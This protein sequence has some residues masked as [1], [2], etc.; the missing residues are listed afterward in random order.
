MLKLDTRPPWPSSPPVFY[1]KAAAPEFSLPTLQSTSS[2][3]SVFSRFSSKSTVMGGVICM[4]ENSISHHC[5]PASSRSRGVARSAS[6]SGDTGREDP[7]WCLLVRHETAAHSE[8]QPGDS[9]RGANGRRPAGPAD[10]AAALGGQQEQLN[11]SR[12][13]AGPDG[14]GSGTLL[15]AKPTAVGDRPAL[16]LPQPFPLGEVSAVGTAGGSTRPLK[17]TGLSLPLIQPASSDVVAVGADGQIDSSRRASSSSCLP[18]SLLP[19]ISEPHPPSFRGRAS[20]PS[21]PSVPTDNT[22]ANGPK[23]AAAARGQ[24]PSPSP[25][26]LCPPPPAALQSPPL[27]QLA[28]AAASATATATATAAATASAPIHAHKV[29]SVL[30]SDLIGAAV[31]GDSGRGAVVAGISRCLPP[32]SP[33][34]PP[35]ALIDSW[36]SKKRTFNEYQSDVGTKLTGIA[37]SRRR[38]PPPGALGGITNPS[39]SPTSKDLPAVVS[40]GSTLGPTHVLPGPPSDIKGTVPFSSL[41]DLIWDL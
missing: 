4:S 22:P 20:S 9:P 34:S 19:S 32:S 2:T 7:S 28:Q 24:S 33:S 13:K 14:S 31:D 21:S 29:A 23:P 15:A 38:F 26:P 25:S 12:T 36:T 8:R 16:P 5:S 37:C 35:D 6:A 3:S 11:V 10:P 27:L 30:S 17:P 1:A 39:K 18:S 40:A 41:I